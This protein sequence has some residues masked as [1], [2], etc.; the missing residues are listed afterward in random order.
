[1]IDFLKTRNVRLENFKIYDLT[2]HHDIFAAIV[3]WCRNLKTFDL[4]EVNFYNNEAPEDEQRVLKGEIKELLI[5]F[6]PFPLLLFYFLLIG[7]DIVHRG[8]QKS[9]GGQDD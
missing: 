1:M 8:S 2:E 3:K 4:P 9:Y 7:S 5:V 6:C